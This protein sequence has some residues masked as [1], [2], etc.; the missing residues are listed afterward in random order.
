MTNISII[1]INYNTFQLTCNCIESVQKFTHGIEYEIILVD[2]ASTECEPDLFLKKFPNITLIASDVNT[3]FAGGNNLGLLKAVGE[4]ILLLNS[5]TE[6]IENSIKICFDF[7]KTDQNI[8]A[9][10]PKLIFENGDVQFCNESFPSIRKTLFELFRLQKI[11]KEFGGKYLGRTFYEKNI[12]VE[13]DWIWG[14]CFLIK[15][16]VIEKMENKKFSERFFMYIEDLEWC[17]IIRKLKYKIYYQPQTKIIHHCGK[18][19]AKSNEMIKKN[20]KIVYQIYFNKVKIK[21][22]L[23]LQKLLRLSILNK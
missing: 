17:I 21:I 8:G 9:L 7:I 16:E 23:F 22:Y 1:I 4:Y 6:L 20:I 14:T 3:G 19:G 11:F 18:S 5:D 15:R 2:N 13:T 10:S 12:P